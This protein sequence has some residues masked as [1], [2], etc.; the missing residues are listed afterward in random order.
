MFVGAKHIVC[1]VSLIR[2]EVHREPHFTGGANKYLSQVS[3][4]LYLEIYL[5]SYVYFYEI[6]YHNR[7]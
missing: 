5:G 3:N 1:A 2:L 6:L 4:T 7:P